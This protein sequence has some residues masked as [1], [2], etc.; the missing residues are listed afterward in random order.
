MGLN[1]SGKYPVR[2]IGRPRLAGCTAL[3][4]VHGEFSGVA[5]M[6]APTP[7]LF[8]PLLS[9]RKVKKTGRHRLRDAGPFS[10]KNLA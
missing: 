5:A 3:F 4:A 10:S 8:N 6:V 1:G 2:G 9:G 7:R